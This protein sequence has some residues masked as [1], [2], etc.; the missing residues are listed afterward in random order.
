MRQGMIVVFEFGHCLDR[1]PLKALGVVDDV[2]IGKGV[3]EIHIKPVFWTQ[4]SPLSK[5]LQPGHVIA[6]LNAEAPAF[7]RAS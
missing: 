5:W 4:G 1:M 3:E 6:V 7:A 2:R